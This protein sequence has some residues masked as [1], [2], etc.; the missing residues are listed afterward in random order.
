MS[1]KEFGSGMPIIKKISYELQKDYYIRIV[2]T[3]APLQHLLE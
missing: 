2:T 1:F 3:T